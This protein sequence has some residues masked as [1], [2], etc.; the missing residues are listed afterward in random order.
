MVEKTIICSFDYV[1]V[2]PTQFE[3][4]LHFQIPTALLCC[5]N[6]NHFQ[7]FRFLQVLILS[8]LFRPPTESTSPGK[9]PRVQ[10]IVQTMPLY[11]FT[12]IPQV[13]DEFNPL[14]HII[15]YTLV[16]V[17]GLWGRLGLLARCRKYAVCCRKL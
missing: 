10:G 7:R 11:S 12:H 4:W 14:K 6:I 5:P 15:E 2:M 16:G 8:F 13:L 9:S 17:Y 3:S 1:V